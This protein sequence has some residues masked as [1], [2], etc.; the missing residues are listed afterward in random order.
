MKI[1][2]ILKKYSDSQRLAMISGNNSITY[3][4]LWSESDALASYIK[5][6]FKNDTSPIIV[7]GHKHPYMLVAFLACVKSGH[8][9][10]PIDITVPRA[11]CEQ[12][13]D[14]VNPSLILTTEEIKA[15]NNFKM[16]HIMEEDYKS[17]IHTAVT[18]EDYVKDDSVYYIIFTSGSTGEPKGVQITYDALNNFVTWA[19]TL[20]K[21]KKEN[22]R[23]INQ[24]PFSFD[25]S[26]MDL[27]MSLAS[28][29]CL[30]AISKEIQSDYKKLFRLIEKSNANVWVSTPSFADFCM[31][32]RSFSQ[33]LLPNLELFLFCG[34]TLTNK[35]AVNLIDRFPNAEIYNTYGPTESTVAVTNIL[36]D[37]H[38]NEKH[39]PLP[40]GRAKPGTIIRIMKDNNV[41]PEGEKGEIVIFGNTVS[42]GYFKNDEENKKRFFK[43]IIDGKEM[44]AYRTG[45]KGYISDDC[46]F[47]CGR[48]D[49]QVKLHGYRIEIEDIEKNLMKVPGVDR[50]V[51]IPIYKNT[52]VNYLKAFCVYSGQIEKEFTTKKIIKEQLSKTIPDYMIPKKISFVKDIPITPNGK[53]DRKKIQEIYNGIL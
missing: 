18:H 47:Y 39:N 1:L 43:Q 23:F 53:V 46:L 42:V 5:Q 19:L 27:Y 9:Y 32:D 49:L 40:V 50:A 7:Y 28:E 2:D 48:L 14:T 17:N 6:N 31:A 38:I 24:A 36:I 4:K 16:L 10:V 8:A 41:L 51:V 34:E 12:I 29:S 30:F 52:K 22:K 13:I 3:K 33:E 25:L 21:H 35:T 15:Y 37:R 45:D 26:V 44:P 20:G 11:R